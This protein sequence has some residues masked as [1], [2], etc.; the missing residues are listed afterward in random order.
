MPSALD[1]SASAI[2]TLVAR[3]F[4][5]VLNGQNPAAAAELLVADFTVHH[6][7][8]GTVQGAASLAAMFTSFRTGFPDL[9]Y[10]VIE[11]IADGDRAAVRW[12]ATGTHKGEFF[13][14]AGTERA[15]VVTGTDVFHAANGR[16]T[17]SWVSS[18]FFG[19]F[20]Q[21]GVFPP[22]PKGGNEA[23]SAS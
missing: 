7:Q 16:L 1:G 15:V 5:D 14:I 3:F 17:E 21:L 18:D 11:I 10:S 13:G 23:K 2:A 19:L 6:P 9:R 8:L 20:T 4:A 22:L 12:R